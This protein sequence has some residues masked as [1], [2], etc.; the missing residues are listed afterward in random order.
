MN[1]EGKYVSINNITIKEPE[2]SKSK[3]KISYVVDGEISELLIKYS[4]P[5]DIEVEDARLISIAPLVN[6][7]LFTREIEAEF[8]VDK[9][10]YNFFQEMMR[11]NSTEVYV[12]KL[13]KRPE[14]FK[15]ELLPDKPDK[16]E[17]EYIP[18]MKL[19]FSE[20][21]K[22]IK[23]DG[24]VAILSSGG[25]E[26]LLTY[27]MMKEIGSEVF[28]I[29][30]NESG[31]HWR[32]AKTAYDYMMKNDPNTIR[33]WTT[34]DRFYREMNV[35]VSA[36]NERA[37]KMWSDTYP[38]QLFIFPVYIFTILPYIRALRI[39]YVMKGD[40]FDDP[41]N[42]KPENGIRHFYG[43]YDQTMEFD[44]KITEYFKIKEFNTIFFSAVR[45]I[46][47]YVEERILFSRYPEI[48]ALQRSCHSCH[49]EGGN[50]VPC[51]K[52]SK[53]NG[54]LL[55]LL[56]NS[57]DPALIKYKK[58]DIDDFKNN[59]KDRLYRLDDDEREHSMFKLS[60]GKVGKPHEHIEKIHD[61]I[62]CCDSNY[63]PEDFKD[64]LMNIMKHY[65]NGITK[66]KN[67]EWN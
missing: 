35:R 32:T 38:I 57:I 63:I 8:P 49:Y 12:N 64:K 34:V 66:L 58:E 15:K 53:C 67:G 17:A 51:G 50:I 25:K 65:T 31:G 33:A 62:E 27:G 46:S 4:R 29:Y 52:C 59:Y 47:G 21:K 55:F 45:G 28:P 13:I 48:A 19:K 41:R 3:I 36:L 60:N 5:L 39:S 56:A 14:F 54:V 9:E 22:P 30:V 42:M 43:I 37:L 24:S 26:S 2:I 20:V 1:K 44:K 18:N 7:S 16:E 40:E 61:C 10:D 11:I 23:G 6:Y